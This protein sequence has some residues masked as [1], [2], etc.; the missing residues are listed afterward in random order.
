METPRE[1]GRPV[2][3]T[4]CR[5]TSIPGGALP[6]ATERRGARRPVIGQTSARSTGC[7]AAQHRAMF[8]FRPP[9]AGSPL[10]ARSSGC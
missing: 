1:T 4:C 8:I 3:F 7:L 5:T 9:R 2:T 10:A 6:E